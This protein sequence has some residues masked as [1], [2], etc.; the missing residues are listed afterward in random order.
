MDVVGRKYQ[1]N[2]RCSE[3]SE[4]ASKN[5]IQCRWRSY[6][7]HKGRQLRGD[8]GKPHHGEPGFQS[9]EE[10]DSGQADGR[11]VRPASAIDVPYPSII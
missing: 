3:P 5:E 7:E 6:A 10:P 2:P 4:P 11:D 8:L 9:C 1:R